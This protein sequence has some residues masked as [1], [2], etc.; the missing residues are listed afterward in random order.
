MP[1]AIRRHLLTVA[2]HAQVVALFQP[3]EEALL[4]E[5]QKIRVLKKTQPQKIDE[6]V[7][8]IVEGRAG[9]LEKAC[10]L[11]SNSKQRVVAG[12]DKAIPK[13]LNKSIRGNDMAKLMHGIHGALLAYKEAAEAEHI[14]MTKV[15]MG[16]FSILDLSLIHI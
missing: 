13:R 10:Q 5:L 16:P 9:I 11:K 8:P 7:K 3:T 14:P 6:C 15:V 12:L 2:V 4:G 1:I